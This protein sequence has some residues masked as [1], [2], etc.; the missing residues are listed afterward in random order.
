MES[1]YFDSSVFLAIFKGEPNGKEIRS[2][3]R[4]L[5]KDKIRIQTSIITIQEVSVL[6]FRRGGVATDNHAKVEKLARIQGLSRDMSVAAARLEAQI[7]D[8]AS[9]NSGQIKEE[10]K[11]RKWDCFHIATALDLKCRTLYTCDPGMLNMKRR[12]GIT[13]MDFARPQPRNLEL[14]LSVTGET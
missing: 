7:I 2:L 10:N 12:L 8:S 6:S 11:R 3:L 1:V 13:G 5:R 4:E 14:T 9:K